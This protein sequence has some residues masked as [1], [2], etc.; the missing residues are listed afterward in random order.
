MRGGTPGF[1]FNK[2]SATAI[3]SVNQVV[4]IGQPVASFKD[5]TEACEQSHGHPSTHRGEQ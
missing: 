1:D 5:W 2:L 3:R 4:M